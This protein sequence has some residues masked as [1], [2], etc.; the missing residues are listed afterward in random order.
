MAEESVKETV[1]QQTASS[2]AES[3]SEK[4]TLVVEGKRMTLFRKALDKVIDKCLTSVTYAFAFV[5]LN[6]RSVILC[7]L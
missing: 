2:T 6:Y 4:P 1:C 7:R 3:S 5:N